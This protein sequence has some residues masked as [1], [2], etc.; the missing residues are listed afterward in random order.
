MKAVAIDAEV[1]FEK[2]IVV[3]DGRAQ[4]FLGAAV[5]GGYLET[6]VRDVADRVLLFVGGEGKNR[7]HLDRLLAVFLERFEGLVVLFCRIDAAYGEHRVEALTARLQT[8]G[9]LPVVV[10]N[11]I[12]NLLDPIRVQQSLSVLGGVELVHVLLAF[13]LLETRAHIIV[14]HLEF[15]H[16]FIADRIGDDVGMKLTAKHTGGGLCAAGVLWK[17][18][19]SS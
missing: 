4:E 19:S 5:H 11:I 3:S 17:D 13:H 6:F 9:L 8:V 16:L 10:E 1:G 18:G 14:V 15:E 7:G 2:G 12:R